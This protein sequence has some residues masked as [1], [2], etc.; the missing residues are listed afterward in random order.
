M[1][2]Q[3]VNYPCSN[4]GA[5]LRYKPGTMS[6]VCEYCGSETLIKE[7]QEPI[8]I[9]EN[10]LESFLKSFEQKGL[11][12][13][14]KVV[15]CTNC[16]AEVMLEPN[17]TSENCPFC[18]TPLL[19][20][21]ASVCQ[22]HRPQYVLPF[23]IDEKKAQ[24]QFANWIESLW[25]TPND[26][27]NYKKRHDKMKGVYLPYWTYDCLT[28]TTYKG[29]RGVYY[30]ETE[31]YY[32]KVNGE[33]VS[34]T[35][36]VRKTRWYPVSGVVTHN[37]DDVLVPA[38]TSLPKQFLRALEPWNTQKLVPFDAKFLAGVRTEQYQISLAEGYQLAKNR[39]QE[40]IHYLI[41]KDIG[42]DEQRITY[43]STSYF[44]PTFKHILL[45]V[46]VSAFR[47]RGKLYQ[48]L[49]NAQTG[50]VHGEH[51]YSIIKIALLVI[52]II[53]IVVLYFYYGTSY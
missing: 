19:I 40:A 11:K 42:G 16:S 2:E 49:I 31:T 13:E 4:C 27:K 9:Q 10:D 22:V 33:Y 14:T 23:L 48:F 7:H 12:Y 26:L 51:P 32:E 37:F 3:L 5:S 39:M 34:R 47:Y 1:S 24:Q 52:L 44:N 38:T 18:T 15:K 43:K 17:I 45:P 53:S 41:Q 35:R 21:K 6:L 50:K 36:K 8:A 20:E 25:F 30:Y 28:T 46:W 29:E